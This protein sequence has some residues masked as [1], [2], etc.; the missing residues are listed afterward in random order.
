MSGTRG[1]EFGPDESMKNSKIRAACR[2]GAAGVG[3]TLGEYAVKVVR[4]FG[5][6]LHVLREI[7]PEAR[8]GAEKIRVGGAKAEIVREHADFHMVQIRFLSAR[9]R[10]CKQKENGER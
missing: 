6:N 1:L 3:K 2:N 7:H 9:E 10:H 4:A 8:T 5:F